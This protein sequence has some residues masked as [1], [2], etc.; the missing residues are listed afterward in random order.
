[1]KAT[2]TFLPKAS[3]P[4]SVAGPSAIISPALTCWPFL[5]I[6]RWLKQVF[7]LVRMNFEQVVYRH[8]LFQTIIFTGG[9]TSAIMPQHDAG[10]IHIDHLP[11]PMRHDGNAG[12]LGD[13]PF[14]TRAD[15]RRLVN[16]QAA[17]PGAACS[18]P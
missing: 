5:T 2:V 11:I 3:S 15:Q 1:M 14:D 17:P 16:D 8:R 4:W 12:V 9:P 6:G 18:I 13:D 7:W 10:G